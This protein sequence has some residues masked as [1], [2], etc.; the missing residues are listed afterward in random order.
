MSQNAIQI[1]LRNGSLLK[2]AIRINQKKF[3]EAFIDNP[4]G[5]EFSDIAILGMPDRNRALQGDIVAFRIKPRCFWVVK[6]KAYL[7]WKQ[8][9]C[10]ATVTNTNVNKDLPVIAQVLDHVE[11]L[12]LLDNY[13]AVT[14]N[15]N[16]T[17][18]VSNNVFHLVPSGKCCGEEVAQFEE[19]LDIAA[20]SIS[21]FENTSKGKMSYRVLSD[22]P[23]EEWD[24]PDCCLQ[25]TAQVVGIIEQKNLR[26][27]VGRL[28][29]SSPSQRNWAK[30]SPTDPKM[31]RMIIEESRL[32]KGFFKKPQDFY[33]FMFIAKI[34]EWPE[35]SVMAYGEI[36]KQ[37]GP[38]G[39]INV[40]TEG[41]LYI[42]GIDTRDFPEEVVSCLPS[43]SSET[44]WEIEKDEITRRRDLREEIVFTIDPK[45][46]RDIDDALS[47]KRCKNID[48]NGT[49]GWEVGVH[50]AD[51]S[52]YVLEN[53]ALD[54]WA[55]N[56]ATSVYLVNKVIPMLPRLLCE[57]MCSL[58]AGVDRLTFSVMWKLDDMG[59][60]CHE[61]FGRTVIRSKVKLTYEH[62]QDFIENPSKDFLNADIPEIFDEVNIE[63][64]KEKVLQLHSVAKVLRSKRLQCGSLKLDQPKLCFTLDEETN[65]PIGLSVYQI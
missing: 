34:L 18:E 29:I 10:S 17:A 32:P 42:N 54:K 25:K 19:E 24:L 13:G 22:L 48:G 46:A 12:N 38:I 9:R 3:E 6:D 43:V 14:T 7:A 28:K 16:V 27:A 60:I 1:G 65:M 62:A 58:N 59:N 41:L 36:Q 21:D 44:G 30:F 39:D 5:D 47:I 63:Q 23:L 57:E 31:P 35:N 55:L 26:L 61:W 56:R 40:E 11:E 15:S 4:D 33:Q 64:I 45:T 2:G 8:G 52:F 49:T 37:L 51:V 53:T 50:I 20:N